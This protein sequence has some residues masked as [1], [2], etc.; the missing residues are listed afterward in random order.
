MANE[1]Q[2][3]ADASRRGFDGVGG[4]RADVHAAGLG[5][6]PDPRHGRAPVPRP[7][8]R[9]GRAEGLGAFG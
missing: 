8:H 3:G 7:P 6:C 1:K 4:V 5:A 9:G 2:D